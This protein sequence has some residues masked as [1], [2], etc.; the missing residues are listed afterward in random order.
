MQHHMELRV[1]VAHE[2]GGAIPAVAAVAAG[3]LQ[4][5]G[6]AGEL[7]HGDV[8]HENQTQGEAG[9]ERHVIG[10][11]GAHTLGE[12]LAGDGVAFVRLHFHRVDSFVR[13][14][15]HNVSS[16]DVKINCKQLNRG[17]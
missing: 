8:L 17:D 9:T 4:M 12:V 3:V 11:R 7:L 13:L 5:L 14:S 10:E 16:Y 15:V 1:L 6:I 2:R